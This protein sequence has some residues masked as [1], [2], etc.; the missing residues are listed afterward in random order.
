MRFIKFISIFALI[1]FALS[2][3]S[4]ESSQINETDEIK[5]IGLTQKAEKLR[6]LEKTMHHLVIYGEDV[7]KAMMQGILLE[8]LDNGSGFGIFGDYCFEL[9]VGKIPA[10]LCREFTIGL[11]EGNWS[12]IFEESFL[13]GRNPISIMRSVVFLYRSLENE[14]PDLAKQLIDHILDLINKIEFPIARAKGGIISYKLLHLAGFSG[15]EL[16][17]LDAVQLLMDSINEEGF[18]ISPVDVLNQVAEIASVDYETAWMLAQTLI[19]DEYYLVECKAAIS[20]GLM[21]SDYEHGL[22]LYLEAVNEIVKLEYNQEASKHLP[23]EF[24][25]TCLR[26][27]DKKKYVKKHFDVMNHY[28]RVAIMP[29]LERFKLKSSEPVLPSWFR[30]QLFD[31]IK[32]KFNYPVRIESV[33]QKLVEHCIR[34]PKSNNTEIFV[35]WLLDWI[36]KL[37][38]PFD[39]YIYLGRLLT[40]ANAVI[41]DN[42]SIAKPK[43]DKIIRSFKT[44]LPDLGLE[45]SLLEVTLFEEPRQFKNNIGDGSVIAGDNEFINVYIG[46]MQYRHYFHPD[47]DAGLAER[48][49]ELAENTER[50]SIEEDFNLYTNL[51]AMWAGWD[52]DRAW[53]MIES[54]DSS[55]GEFPKTLINVAIA[56]KPYA[57]GFSARCIDELIESYTNWEFNLSNPNMEAGLIRALSSI[58]IQWSE[59]LA[60]VIIEYRG[61]NDQALSFYNLKADILKSAYEM[62]AGKNE[63]TRI[64]LEIQN[65]LREDF[66]LDSD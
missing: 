17:M 64:T 19:D 20:G 39:K 63:I 51:A 48:L 59:Q 18:E 53:E 15:M 5:Q 11:I 12:A 27:E 56:T 2:C 37:N 14:Y 3:S 16:K 42:I 30:D 58:S 66:N 6:G 8:Y 49:T 23:F 41:P 54:L 7:D 25:Y 33:Q 65:K 52:D 13:I 22:Q 9:E 29:P 32:S 40:T 43:I 24:A 44:K 31:W 62:N 21:K 45:D 47:N 34:Y 38:S 60:D 57:P 61:E 26:E 50:E 35:G 1:A 46:M 10:D 4:S 28:K 55:N 36:E